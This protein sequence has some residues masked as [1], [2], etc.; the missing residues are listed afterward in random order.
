ML[1]LTLMDTE[2]FV[3]VPMNQVCKVEQIEGGAKVTL[4]RE[5]LRV[6]EPASWISDR[7]KEF[8]GNKE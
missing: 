7:M 5:V 2:M 3:S 4:V 6:T 1:E 8:F